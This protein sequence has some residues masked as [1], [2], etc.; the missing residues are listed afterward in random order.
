MKE[1][2]LFLSY[3]ILKKLIKIELYHLKADFKS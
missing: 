2:F 3:L 1:Y